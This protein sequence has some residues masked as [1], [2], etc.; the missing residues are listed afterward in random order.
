M[1]DWKEYKALILLSVMLVSATAAA[2]VYFAPM[3]F[4][5][6]TRQMIANHELKEQLLYVD[7]RIWQLESQCQEL[8]TEVWLCSERRLREHYELNL[9]RKLLMK[10]LEIGDE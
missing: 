10:E 6:F 7:D 5:G 8:K 1:P 9:E 2:I 3:S 4:A